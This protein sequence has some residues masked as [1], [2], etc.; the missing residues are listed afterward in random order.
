MQAPLPLPGT[1]ALL[2]GVSLAGGGTNNA[3]FNGAISGTFDASAAEVRQRSNGIV[4]GLSAALGSSS[5]NG[6]ASLERQ[7]TDHGDRHRPVRRCRECD[8]RISQRPTQRPRSGRFQPARRGVGDIDRRHSRL[9]RCRHQPPRNPASATLR[10]TADGAVTATANAAG[11]TATGISVSG[12]EFPTIVDKPEHLH[13][14][15]Q[16]RL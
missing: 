15:R 8:R 4:T 6:S 10:L 11:S 1:Q 2:A 5:S 16:R 14:P 12:S 13:R 3:T 7:W 9:Y